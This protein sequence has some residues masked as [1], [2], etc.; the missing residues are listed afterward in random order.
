MGAHSSTCTS[1]KTVST[2]LAVNA[3]LAAGSGLR[4]IGHSISCMSDA[5]VSIRQLH[6]HFNSDNLTV[7]FYVSGTSRSTI[8]IIADLQLT[9]AGNVVFA[10]HLDPCDDETFVS[11]LC[12]GESCSAC[13]SALLSPD[14]GEY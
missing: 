6:V 12:P 13:S 14:L 10:R 2:F 11:E 5:T 4:T 1:F 7:S 8:N 9:A 3:A